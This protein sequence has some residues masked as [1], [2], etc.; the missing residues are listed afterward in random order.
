MF[1]SVFEKTCT[2]LFVDKFFTAIPSGNISIEYVGRS[3]VNRFATNA[4]KHDPSNSRINNTNITIDCNG[5]SITG[6][7]GGAG[8]DSRNLIANSSA[9][10][11]LTIQNCTIY[12]FTYSIL[13]NGSKGAD[14]GP[15]GSGRIGGSGGNIVIINSNLTT[16][17]YNQGGVGGTWL[18]N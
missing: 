16:D 12:N 6:T 13:A 1:L 18:R 4:I 10:S 5:Y 15:S 8:I 3:S 7:N 9:Y 17:I 2:T 11:P 14:G